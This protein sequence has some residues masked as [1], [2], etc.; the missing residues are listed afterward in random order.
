MSGSLR[1][2]SIGAA[3]AA[4]ALAAI[5]AL[6]AMARVATDAWGSAY[7]VEGLERLPQV[8]TA[9]VL[10]TSPFG[11]RG[12]DKRTLSWRMDAA[13][14]LW[15]G[16]AVES[17]IVSGI[18]I[19]A[20]Y[21]EASFMRDELVARGVPAKAITLDPLGNRTW[22]S[23]ARARYVFGKRRLVIVSQRDH[24]GRALFLAHHAGIEAWG[25]AARG[26]NYGGL[27]GTLIGDMTSLRA[28]VDI[29]RQR[30]DRVIAAGPLR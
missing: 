17:F 30:S 5:L 10:G 12:Q 18:R 6:A 3:V 14:G 25:I 19:G 11:V 15:H 27:Y 26:D 13:A 21:D 8:D 29:V 24:L 20:D 4:L 28:Y 1:A 7:V 16:G 2:L 22:D 23:I 9:L